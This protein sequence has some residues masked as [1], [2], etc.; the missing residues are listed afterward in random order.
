MAMIGGGLITTSA[1]TNPPDPVTE[2]AR[3]EH[4]SGGRLGVF[5]ADLA[6]GRMLAHRADERFRLQSSFKAL[7]AA[8]I[9]HEAAAARVRLAETVHYSSTDLL[10]ASPVTTSNVVSGSMTIG[11]LCA[12]IMAYSDNAAANLL[13]RRV[14]GPAALTAFLRSIGDTTT[15]LD[16]Q[17]PLLDAAPYPA[18]STTPRA[19]VSTIAR[20][21]TGS[22]LSD[23]EREQWEA[24][25]ASNTVGRRRLRASFPASWISGDRTGTADG[26]CNDIAFA[27]RSGRAPLLIA[28]YY[29]APGMALDAQEAVLREVGRIVVDWQTKE[30]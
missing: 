5:V 14:G 25:M 24:W 6:S 22:V 27:R 8:M 10:E 4:H 15:Q 28:A 29:D 3:L 23:A 7:L 1:C 18:D 12:A 19:I 13:L 17:E 16:H 20:L 9:L 30:V 21:L 11:A 26:V 2:L